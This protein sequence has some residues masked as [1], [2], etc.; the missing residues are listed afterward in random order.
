LLD[1]YANFLV[2]LQLQQVNWL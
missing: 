1:F 2:H